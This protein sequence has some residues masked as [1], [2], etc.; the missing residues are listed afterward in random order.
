MNMS[1]TPGRRPADGHDSDLLSLDQNEEILRRFLYVH[2]PSMDLILLGMVAFGLLI[3]VL[4]PSLVSLWVESLPG[5]GLRFRLACVLAGLLVGCFSYGVARFTLYRANQRLVALAN[6]DPLTGLANHR[7]FV[8]LLQSGLGQ[9][10]RDGRELGLILAD[11]DQFKQVNDSEGHLVGN[12]VLVEVG[13]LL[14]SHTGENGVAF[15]IGG[16]EFAVILPGVT[17]GGV[18]KLAERLRVAVEALTLP[19]LPRVTISLGVAT[20]PENASSP[21]ELVK[22]ADDAMYC[23]KRGG[24]NQTVRWMPESAAKVEERAPSSA[25]RQGEPRRKRNPR[26]PERSPATA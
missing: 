17:L 22:R 5:Q 10:K 9:A 2:D 24:R 13:R 4:F 1:S 14:E 12:A 7:R 19:G 15:R 25:R 11:L 21:N 6:L 16:E 8:D 20:F 26:R 3:G 18:L 23:A